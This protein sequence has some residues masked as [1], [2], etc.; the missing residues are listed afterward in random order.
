MTPLR[1]RPQSKHLRAKATKVGAGIWRLE[2]KASA[3]GRAS[4]RRWSAVRG[5][6]NQAWEEELPHVRAKAGCHERDRICEWAEF[7][8][9]RAPAAAEMAVLPMQRKVRCF[10]RP[11]R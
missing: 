4:V 11:G 1:K 10:G 3:E 5:P 9:Y 7:S 6:R 8:N 2:V